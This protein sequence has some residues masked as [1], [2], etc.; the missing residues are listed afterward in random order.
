MVAQ[1]VEVTLRM[2]VA[3]PSPWE[4]EVRGE[5][6]A[7]GNHVLALYEILCVGVSVEEEG[8]HPVAAREFRLLLDSFAAILGPA[9]SEMAGNNGSV[10]QDEPE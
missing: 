8:G 3:Y 1:G 7:Q 2:T 5:I 9:V 6:V 4:L 10:H